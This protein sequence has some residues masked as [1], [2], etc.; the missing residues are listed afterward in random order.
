[1]VMYT[2]LEV[3]RIGMT[4]EELNEFY[5]DE[6][7]RTISIDATTN[8]RDFLDDVEGSHVIVHFTRTTGQIL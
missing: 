8:D 2:S 3:A 7:I 5:T 4:R 1:M 6:E